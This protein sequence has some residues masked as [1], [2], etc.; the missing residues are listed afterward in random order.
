MLLALFAVRTLVLC[1]GQMTVVL[2]T[3]LKHMA[4]HGLEPKHD[5]KHQNNIPSGGSIDNGTHLTIPNIAIYLGSSF[6][7]GDNSGMSYLEKRGGVIATWSNAVR[8]LT[9][10]AESSVQPPGGMSNFMAR[11][12]CSQDEPDQGDEDERVLQCSLWG[13]SARVL[14]TPC[15][16][17][18][19]GSSGP[20]CKFDHAAKDFFKRYSISNEN[21]HDEGHHGGSSGVQWLLYSDDDLVVRP[22]LL[23]R[24]LRFFDPH[25][26]IVMGAN[27]AGAKFRGA[28]NGARVARGS[29][30]ARDGEVARGCAA[31]LDPAFGFTHSDP[32]NVCSEPPPPQRAGYRKGASS[33]EGLARKWAPCVDAESLKACEVC[34]DRTM[35][36]VDKCMG[37]HQVP[38][39]SDASHACT[40]TQYDAHKTS[41]HVCNGQAYF[42]GNM[43]PMLASAEAL[44]RMAPVLKSGT[45]LRRI[46]GQ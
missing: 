42:P 12:G 24:F 13:K 34:V 1:S 19:F 30:L 40:H 38:P 29:C 3:L 43:Q 41:N 22:A 45:T 28:R 35:K 8:H 31:Q 10:V 7:D 4:A 17:S 36:A 2:G 37:P 44:R 33:A 16:S 9:L 32:T 15:E 26:A 6:A 39:P 5:H 18:W 23:Q 20:C 25:M 27:K 14:L 11:F 21:S 46:C